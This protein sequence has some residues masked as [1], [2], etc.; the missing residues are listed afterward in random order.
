[1][2]GIQLVLYILLPMPPPN[3]RLPLRFHKLL[4]KLTNYSIS[5]LKILKA[6]TFPFYR[7]AGTGLLL[8]DGFH[9]TLDLLMSFLRRTKP[10]LTDPLQAAPFYI[11]PQ[12]TIRG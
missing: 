6:L 11:V 10:S 1:M 8:G 3:N 9:Q 12:A 7:Q 4:T 5:S 2:W